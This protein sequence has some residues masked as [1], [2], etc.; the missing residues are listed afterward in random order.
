[1]ANEA[2]VLAQTLIWLD[3]PLL[4]IHPVIPSVT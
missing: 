4:S 1:M 3:K 2:L